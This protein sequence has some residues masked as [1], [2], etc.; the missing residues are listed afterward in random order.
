MRRLYPPVMVQNQ[1]GDL[2]D[3]VIVQLQ[4]AHDIPGHIRPKGRVSAEMVNAVRIRRAAGRLG[5]I[6]QEQHESQQGAAVIPSLRESR[7]S[8]QTRRIRAEPEI[9]FRQEHGTHGC[10]YVPADGK[11]VMRVTLGRLHAAVE[12]R[13]NNGGDAR[14]PRCAQIVRV[15]GPGQLHQLGTDPFRADPR[16]LPGKGAHGTPCLRLHGKIQLRGKT[17]R[18]QDAQGILRKACP[19][20]SHGA[21]HAML[22][23]LYAAEQ[24]DH[25]VLIA[26][27][28]GVDGKIPAPQ[29]LLQ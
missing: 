3:G 16:E 18:P 21:D 23:I 11:A 19:G 24:V 7:Q 15:R 13:E 22:Q 5:D 1:E 10:Q 14:F 29:I 26:A 25:A 27:G 6:M 17:D 9:R 8:V 28:H 4:P 20:I 2:S 12:F